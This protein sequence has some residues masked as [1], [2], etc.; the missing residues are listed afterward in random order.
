MAWVERPSVGSGRGRRGGTGRE[1]HRGACT[2]EGPG[3]AAATGCRKQEGR[4]KLP[5]MQYLGPRA[6]TLSMSAGHMHSQLV[7]S[8]LTHSPKTETH[9]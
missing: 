6:A 1:W 9:P 5:L 4:N 8:D 7:L 2:L 3:E